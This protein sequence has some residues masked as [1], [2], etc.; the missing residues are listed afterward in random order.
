VGLSDFGVQVK[1]AADAVEE[2]A[3]AAQADV[4]LDYVWLED[5]T[6]WD[7]QRYHDLIRRACPRM[8]LS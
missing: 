4:G 1:L 7:W 5:V 3:D 6:Y 8:F 2:I